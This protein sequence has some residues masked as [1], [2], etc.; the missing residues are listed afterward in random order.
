MHPFDCT[1]P[2][3]MPAIEDVID[4][5]QRAFDQH[6]DDECEHA[7]CPWCEQERAR[8]ED[9]AYDDERDPHPRTREPWER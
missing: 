9:R 5:E 4:D 1:C 8:G 2:L 6:A 3:C 7:T